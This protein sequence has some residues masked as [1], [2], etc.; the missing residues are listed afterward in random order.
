MGMKIVMLLN[1]LRKG[2]PILLGLSLEP[3]SVLVPTVA[4]LPAWE[5]DQ[6]RH[7]STGLNA[8]SIQL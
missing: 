1:G 6:D 7:R 3:L 2:E 4:F 8:P 5:Y